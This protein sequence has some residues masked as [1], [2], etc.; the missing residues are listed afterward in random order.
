MGKNK[1]VSC[2][3]CFKPMRSNNVTRHMKIHLKY[4]TEEESENIC[5]EIL[6]DL[7][8]KVL[9][10][11]RSDVKLKYGEHDDAYF[12]PEIKR[13]YHEAGEKDAKS[14]ERKIG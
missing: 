6:L 4:T 10:E 3:T 9:E 11:N 1:Q 7:V 12:E 13:K 5:K 2:K 14:L 8:D